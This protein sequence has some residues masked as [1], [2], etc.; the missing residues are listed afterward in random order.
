VV[1]SRADASCQEFRFQPVEPVLLVDQDGQ[2]T[3]RQWRFTW[4]GGA[5]YTVRDAA[6]GRPF[7]GA[8]G[9]WTLIPGTDGMWTLALVGTSTTKTVNVLIP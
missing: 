7:G 3:R 8:A 4:A 9:R 2:S 6:S 5:E 1:N